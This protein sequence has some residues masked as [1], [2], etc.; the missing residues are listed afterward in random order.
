MK[1]HHVQGSYEWKCFRDGKIGSSDIGVIMGENPWKNP[2]RL[3]L[4]K[5]KRIEVFETDA[6]REGTRLEP[7]IRGLY[8]DLTGEA[9]FPCV[10]EH[11]HYP[12]FIASLDGLSFCRTK[13]AEFKSANAK[14]HAIAQSGQVPKHHY[15]QCQWQMFHASLGEMDYVSYGKECKTLAIIKV[16]RDQE[17]IVR[18]VDKA[19]EFLKYLQNDVEPPHKEFENDIT[20]EMYAYF[21]Q[22]HNVIE[23]RKVLEQKEEE[24][25]AKVLELS[26]GREIQAAGLKIEKCSRNGGVQYDNIPALQNINLD[27]Y[28]K[29]ATEYWKISIY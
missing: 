25:K 17:Y 18:A 19:L 22:L 1:L 10:I 24:L 26:K 27:Q 2:Y 16:Q 8:E 12:D 13:A 11:P 5:T 3:W 20:N 14:T 7:I 4:E 15:G 23:E 29:P 21:V 28:R 9:M 6:M